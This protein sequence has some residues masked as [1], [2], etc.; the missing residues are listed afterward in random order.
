M[1][2]TTCR[3]PV[4][5][6]LPNS[7]EPM[8]R[9]C[10]LDSVNKCLPQRSSCI[11][12]TSTRQQCLVDVRSAFLAWSLFSWQSSSTGLS[13]ASLSEAKR[14]SRFHAMLSSIN[15]ATCLFQFWASV[16]PSLIAAWDVQRQ[17]Y[18]MR[19]AAVM[20]R[21]PIP[22]SHT[23]VPWIVDKDHRLISYSRCERLGHT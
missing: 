6:S 17:R 16:R 10:L 3:A 13:T 23:S 11:G 14:C 20:R 1:N 7:G 5:V 2:E 22:Q 19:D 8:P 18:H 4:G 21:L 12:A 9:S 15:C